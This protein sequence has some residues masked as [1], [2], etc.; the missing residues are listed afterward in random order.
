VIALPGGAM[1]IRAGFGSGLSVRPGDPPDRVWAVCDR[2]PNLKAKALADLYGL[3]HPAAQAKGAKIM[4]RLD[5]GPSL[6]ELTIDGD[7][8][9]LVRTIRLTDAKGGPISG[10]PLAGSGHVR[11]EPAFD[12]AGQPLTPDPGG[13][14]SEGLVALRD[15]GFWV[16]DEYGPS[17]L[18]FDADGRLI[19]RW[20]P[21]GLEARG[22]AKLPAIAARRQINRGFEAL[23]L[24]DDERWLFFAFQSPLAHPDEQAHEGARHVRIWRLD[25]ATGAVAAQYLY[26]LDPPESFIRDRDKGP[27]GRADIK[28]SEI[29]WI[30]GDDLLVLERGSET[31]KFYRV[32]LTPSC[33]I[34]AEHLDID[35]RPTIEQLSGEEGH[36]PLPSLAKRLIFSSDDHAQVTADLEGMA[37]LS[38]IDLLLVSDNDFG[39]EGAE[40]SFWLLSF[41][42]PLVRA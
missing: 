15:G 28:V 31:T 14:D 38:A 32:T 24:S 17:L 12:L 21:V 1:R 39:V 25:A 30:G 8:V 3:D 27:F 5:H 11:A 37:W 6:A 33:V 22:E 20:L 41:D 9:R 34:D 10:V 18:R 42:E 40:T 36:L 4:P 35:T 16:G 13:T 7:E 23:A 19:H 29:S 2:G 26:P